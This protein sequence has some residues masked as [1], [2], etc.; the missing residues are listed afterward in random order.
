MYPY[1]VEICI[2]TEDVHK[3]RQAAD[4]GIPPKG[5]VHFH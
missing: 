2:T 4:G 3:G 5:L 1:K